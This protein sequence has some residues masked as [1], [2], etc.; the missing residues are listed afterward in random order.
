MKINFCS[1][2]W[3]QY[4]RAMAPDTFEIEY[5]PQSQA[6]EEDDDLETIAHPAWSVEDIYN[7]STDPH[8]QLDLY[9][10]RI[11][12]QYEVSNIGKMRRGTLNISNIPARFC[13]YQLSLQFLHYSFVLR[14]K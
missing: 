13:R 3:V 14:V 8:E 11:Q 6:F 9:F 12:Y 10:R 5:I 2:A 1:C 4:Y 7:V